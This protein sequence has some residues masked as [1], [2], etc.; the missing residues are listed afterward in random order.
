MKLFNENHAEVYCPKCKKKTP[1]IHG[2]VI[3]LKKEYKKRIS[4]RCSKCNTKVSET[5]I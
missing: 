1:C 2:K 3:I 4:G 5:W